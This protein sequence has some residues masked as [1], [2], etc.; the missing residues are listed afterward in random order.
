[1]SVY[2]PD[3]STG[4]AV[5][6]NGRIILNTTDGGTSW[7]PLSSGTSEYLYSVYFTDANTGYVVGGY[8]TILKTTNGGFP[9]GV[10]NQHLSSNSLKIYPNPTSFNVTIENAG[11]GYISILNLYGQQLLKQGITAPTNTLD[12]ST[13]P[14]GIYFVKVTGETSVQ[15]R[16]FVKL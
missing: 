5:G 12:V 14:S 15:V 13:L 4:Y 2:F 16:K 7:I 10:N 1:M 9:V 3:A 6:N 11:K 8:G